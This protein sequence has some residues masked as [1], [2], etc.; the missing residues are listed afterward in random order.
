MPPALDGL[1]QEPRGRYDPAMALRPHRVVSIVGEYLPVF[2]LAVACE[3]FGIE[4][5]E[6]PGWNYTHAVAAVNPRP[7][8]SPM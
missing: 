2:E 4:R 6:I 5:N 7:M 8:R 1:G 3:V